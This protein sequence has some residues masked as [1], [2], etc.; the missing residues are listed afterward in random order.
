MT[1]CI[2]SSH[3]AHR[4][5]SLIP[6]HFQQAW[7]TASSSGYALLLGIVS[8]ELMY[9]MFY[10]RVQRICARFRSAIKYAAN[11]AEYSS[12]L[13]DIYVYHGKFELIAPGYVATGP[14]PSTK[15][16]MYGSCV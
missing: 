10:V 3:N 13:Y 7:A 9:Q 2:T 5:K 12:M 1:Q 16:C 11:S 6:T 15:H 4:Q 8:D 14:E